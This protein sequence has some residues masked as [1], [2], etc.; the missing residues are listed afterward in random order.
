MGARDVII[1]PIVTGDIAGII[2]CMIQQCRAPYGSASSTMTTIETI[3][4]AGIGDHSV[5]AH[6][7]RPDTMIAVNAVAIVAGIAIHL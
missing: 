1:A 6:Q 5:G 7:G 2:V 3:A 4:R